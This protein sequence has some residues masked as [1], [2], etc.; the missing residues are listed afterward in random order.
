MEKARILIVEDEA[1]IVNRLSKLN[2]KQQLGLHIGE[3]FVEVAYINF[4]RMRFVS[5]AAM[6]IYILLWIYDVVLYLSGKWEVS[7]GYQ[8]IF[9][10]HTFLVLFL[11][12][13]QFFFWLNYPKTV[14]E[15]NRLHELLVSVTLIVV[16]LCTVFLALG[17]VLNFGSIVVYLG[18][19]F[20]SASIFLLTNLFGIFLYSGNMA[21]MLILLGTVHKIVGQP[22]NAQIINTVSFTL[23]AFIMSRILFYYSL[24][25][26]RNRK[27]IEEQKEELE[28]VN[29]ELEIKVEER[30]KDLKKAKE[31]AEQANQLKSDFLANMSHEL[32]TPMH[33]VLSFSHIGIK[34]LNSSR[35][36][37][38]DCFD[39]IISAGNRMMD[40][41]DNLLDL[42]KLESGKLEY[43]FA[44]S[45]V[46][47]I[48]NQTIA[49]LRYQL[50]KKEIS[51]AV[52]EATVPTKVICDQSSIVQ[53]IQN[54]LSN[55]I[56]FSEKNKKISI[57]FDTTD[58]SIADKQEESSILSL[59]VS[60]KDEGLGIPGDELDSIFDKFIQSSKTKT[61]AGGTGLGLSICHEIIKAHGGKIWA[62]N[63][64]DGGATFS[65][66]LP[67]ERETQVI[68]RR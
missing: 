54:L 14:E 35:D 58:L 64:P 7:V 6:T 15:T 41:V 65:F 46:F 43:T 24:K 49:G 47:M 1:I 16:M 31:V 57:S 61:G 26:F 13:I 9:Y 34:R 39:K 37:A 5:L 56:R 2:V 52:A 59:L 60:I 62:E 44:K 55:S 48:I 36:K 68:K 38:L 20:G 19:I 12:A 8:I 28:K 53:V 50:E 29:N 42:S 25:D 18:M 21:L 4:L 3:F 45:D 32:R 23:V 10:T 63:N 40:L 33:H 67:Y 22:M 30:T 66:M 27:I 11:G 17:D 51:I